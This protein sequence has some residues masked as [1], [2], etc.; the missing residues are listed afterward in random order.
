MQ[1]FDAREHDVYALEGM[2]AGEIYNRAVERA[3]LGLVVG[4]GVG[5][6][7]WELES[8][9]CVFRRSISRVV[10]EAVADWGDGHDVP[11]D[12]RSLDVAARYVDICG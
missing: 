7:K 5:W 10:F 11:F 8:A 4:V 12:S 2:G 1:R 3:A 9:D 6:E